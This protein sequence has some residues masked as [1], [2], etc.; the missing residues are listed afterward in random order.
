MYHGYFDLPTFTF[1]DEKNIWTGSLYRNFSYRITPVKRKPDDEKKSELH[2]YVWYGIQ[3]FD[4]IKEFEAEYSEE[5]SPEGLESC[6]EKLSAEFEK[7]KTV[8][9]DLGY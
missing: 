6:I 7:F 9:K 1:F 8:R 2:V 5:F 4:N 3:C